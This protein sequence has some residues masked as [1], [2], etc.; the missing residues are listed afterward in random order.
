MRDGIPSSY[1]SQQDHKEELSNLHTAMTHAAD[2][3]QEPRGTHS[4]GENK[5]AAIED[6]AAPATYDLNDVPLVDPRGTIH[7]P[8]SELA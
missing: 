1:L 4:T 3:K 5:V 2:F 8:S 7:L 6:Q